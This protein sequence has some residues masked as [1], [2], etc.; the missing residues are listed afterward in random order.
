MV[1]ADRPAKKAAPSPKAQ[2]A[3][4]STPIAKPAS[5]AVKAKPSPA[6]LPAVVL[7]GNTKVDKAAE[8]KRHQK[9]KQ[10]EQRMAKKKLKSQLKKRT[11]KIKV[12]TAKAAAA[13]GDAEEASNPS[14]ALPALVTSK[15]SSSSAA[16]ATLKEDD[17]KLFAAPSIAAAAAAKPKKVS[18]IG[19]AAELALTAPAG[20]KNKEKVLVL[21]TRGI[22]FRYRH[23]MSD[24]LQLLPHSK[25]DNKLDTKND[26]GVINEVADMKS[27]SSTVFFEVRKKQDLYLWMSKCP[28]GPSVKFLAFDEQP[29]LQLLKEMLTQVFATPRRHHKS[30][31]FFDHVLSFTIADDRI[32]F[33]NYQIITPADGKKAGP[34]PAISLVEVGPRFCMN[35]IKI[36]AGSFGGATLFENPNYISPNAVRSAAKKA[37]A[38]KYKNKIAA[39]EKRKTHVGEH[40]AVRGELDGLF[41][42]EGDSD[43]GSDDFEDSE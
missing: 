30:K 4:P 38:G 28:A 39:R 14:S 27:C 35:P 40:P 20:F 15:K 21:S 31:P 22:T 8:A 11:Q 26:R 43:M 41:A 12:K 19:T 10:I 17:S 42:G 9:A 24:L 36:F 13:G 33:R 18:K 3:A 25:K 37:A 23:L 7:T 6:D 5:K 16:A 1:K 34:G 2:D 32:W 29:H